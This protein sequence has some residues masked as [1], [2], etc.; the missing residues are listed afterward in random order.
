MPMTPEQSLAELLRGDPRR[1]APEMNAILRSIWSQLHAPQHSHAAIE[2]VALFQRAGYVS[3]GIPQPDTEIVVYRGELISTHEP[4][5]SWTTDF[6]IA[7]RYARNYATVGTTQ[8][9]Q[10]TAPPAAV[11]AQFAREAEV[12]VVPAL[13]RDTKSLG[14]VP[15]LTLPKLAPF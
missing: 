11:L 6:Q 5:I 13:I 3:D 8:V 14:Y 12:V 4:G 7:K 9:L 1:D 2:L 10:G 15:H